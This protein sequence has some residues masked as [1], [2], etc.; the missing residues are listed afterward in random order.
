MVRI[1]TRVMRRIR[2]EWNVYKGHVWLKDAEPDEFMT[3]QDY[4][5]TLL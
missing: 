5:P 4:G 2:I 3:S 1:I